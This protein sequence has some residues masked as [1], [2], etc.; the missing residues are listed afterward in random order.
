MSWFGFFRRFLRDRK[1]IGAVAP[2]G[3]ALARAMVAKVGSIQEGESIVE[4]GSGTGAI[5]QELV[6]AFPENACVLI[7]R[8]EAFVRQLRARFPY[9]RV[10]HGNAEDLVPVLGNLAQKTVAIVSGLPM[11]SLPEQTK[12]AVFL[13]IKQ[14][15]PTGGRYVQFTYAPSAWRRVSIPGFRLVCKTRVWKNVP[16]ATVLTFERI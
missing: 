2:S 15:L 14:V 12:T 1:H 3:R 10:V 9:A 4:L 13:A 11:L 16:P 7:E 8:E 6:R 5:T